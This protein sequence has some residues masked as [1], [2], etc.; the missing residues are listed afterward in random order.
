MEPIRV[1]HIL[2]SMNRG[3]AENAIMNYYRH[4]DRDKVQFD[5]LLT[6]PSKCQFEDEIQSLGGRVYRV[7][8][9]TIKNPFPY[10]SG[11]LRFYK[12]YPEYRIVHSHTSSKSFFPLV[13]AKIAGVPVRISHSHGSRSE[14][15]MSG[16]IRDFLKPLLK[17]TATHFIACGNDA[18]EWLYGRNFLK[19]GKVLLFPNV[20]EAEQFVF[21]EDIRERVRITLGLNDSTVVLG[22][23][24]R[25]SSVKNHTFLLSLFS[26]FHEV[27]TD[28][29][30]LLVG[31]GE[32]RTDILSQ[33]SELGIQSQ[34]IMTGVVNNVSD[35][36][37]VM[38]IF[39]LPS[40]NEG[41]PLSIIEAQVSGLRC[42]VSK[43]VPR[44]SDKTGLVSFLSLNEGP[45]YWAKQ[46]ADYI[47]YHRSSHLD[48][49]I[50]AGYDASTSAKKLEQFYLKT[51]NNLIYE[52]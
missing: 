25:F 38:D 29:V 30:L 47:D 2:H 20:I 41:I 39:L 40:I 13:I 7:P 23:T 15:G 6:E 19:K 34:V 52:N 37:Q 46:I 43:G 21:N 26:K 1:L 3:G 24:A 14:A 45:D 51:Y 48:D 44:E 49:I 17:I 12:S 36:E 22:C 18:A 32:L 50:K 31:D 35:Y 28:S 5:F 27:I 4:I 42:F 9:L 10:L 11:V 33:S 8:R 16:K